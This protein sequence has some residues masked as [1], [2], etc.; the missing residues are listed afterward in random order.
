MERRTK[1][2]IIL[3]ILVIVLFVGL[4]I[5]WKWPAEQTQA[6][7]P[8]STT[9]SITPSPSKSTNT[10]TSV[11]EVEKE[12]VVQETSPNTVARTFVERLGSYSTE[13]D[14]VNIE[15]ILPMATA[16]FQKNL[17]AL[18]REARETSDGAYYG[19]ST[20]VITAPKTVSSTAT[21]VVLSLTTQR[22]E[23]I[24]TPGNTT[25]S[26]QSITVTL[27]K[28]GMTWLVDDYAWSEKM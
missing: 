8:S 19:V 26:Y 3:A 14:A 22:E 1:I 18:V 16:S 23:T 17:E 28:S 4:M 13:A 20:I 6:P 11:P 9:S 21:K 10:G 5:W 15:D 2:E 27:V 12:P 7:V 24:D 25:V